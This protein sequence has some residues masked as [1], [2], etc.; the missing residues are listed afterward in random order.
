V[1]ILLLVGAVAGGWWL[2][3]NKM[4][5]SA[6]FNSLTISVNQDTRKL[7]SGETVSLHPRDRVKILSISTNIPLNLNIRLSAEEFDV[8]ALQYEALTLASL[9]PR[10]DPFDRYQFV[11]YIK[12]YNQDMPK[13]GWIRPT[14]LSI[15][16][17]ESRFWSGATACCRETARSTGV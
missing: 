17:V 12:H 11:I 5:E 1:I 16:N 2:W 3:R 7:I 14:E 10:Q 15:M 13:T 8:N 9:L 6:R 4:T